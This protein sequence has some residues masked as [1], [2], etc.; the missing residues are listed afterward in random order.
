MKCSR[1]WAAF[2]SGFESFAADDEADTRELISEVLECGSEVDNQPVRCRSFSRAEE[3]KPDILISDLGMPDEDGY[4]LISKIRA[5]PANRGGH[6]PAAALTAYARAEDRM[7]ASFRISVSPSKT[8][9]LRGV[10]DRR[11]EPG[12][13]RAT[14]LRRRINRSQA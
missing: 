13:A 2:A 1:R 3:H 6:I 9:R 12:R 8:G 14:T 4:A 7:R 11:R 10:S 5:P